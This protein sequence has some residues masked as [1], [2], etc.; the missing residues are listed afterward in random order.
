[1]RREWEPE[2]LVA[3]WT[4]VEADRD[5]IANKTGATRVGFALLLEYFELEGR[6]PRHT[7][8]VPRQAVV[9]VAEQLHLEPSL[10]SAYAS[11]G[12]TIEYH[13]AQI[14]AALDFRECTVEDEERLTGW[15]ADEV[16]PTELGEERQREA[17]LARCRGERIE[18]PASSR[19]ER[20]LRAARAAAEQRFCSRTVARLPEQAVQRL[21]E[22]V[23][24]ARGDDAGG[25][26]LLEELKADPGP[27]GLET[28]LAEINKLARVRLVGLPT[29]LF[30]DASEKLLLAWRARAA[31][32]HPSD[33]QVMGEPLR[34]TL[35]ATLCSV[36]AAEITDG[37][38]DLLIQLVHRINA[39]AERRVEGEVIADLRRVVGKEGIL[40]RLAEAAVEH[41]DETVRCALYPVVGE[42]TLRDLV[43]EAR[44]NQAAFRSRVRMVL[45]SSYS[46]YYRRML[47]KLLSALA[48]RCNNTAY[49]PVMDAIELLKRYAVSNRHYYDA[50]ER[51]PIDGVVPAAWREAVIDER[52]RVERIPY[53]L[54]L[55]A[56]LR[57]AIRRRE[58][59][60]VGAARW[61][62]PEADLP[63][64]FEVNRDVHYAANPAAA[65]RHRFRRRAAHAAGSGA[66]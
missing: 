2:D 35:L 58:I 46:S 18:P 16:C 50:A 37:L 59:W 31:A 52:G 23:E 1:V 20:I 21:A 54:C 40:F 41:P 6:F 5:L 66:G 64:D 53:E 33:L 42:G 32:Q 36:R 43:R 11:A 9:Y 57:E 47:P 60:V 19:V 13:R 3:C 26:G 44:A 22:L 49:R 10:F 25:R 62:D 65:R 61:Q 7:G 34:L 63:Q 27:L 39:R 48:I 4:L 8:E 30:A 38:V 24:D 55:L 29:A 45:R 28:L 17:L 12:R 51:V 14:R 56:T 15:L